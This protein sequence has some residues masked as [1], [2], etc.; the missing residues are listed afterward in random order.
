MGLIT[1]EDIIEEIV[2]EIVDEIDAPS[3]DF[4]NSDGLIIT[5]GEKIYEI[6]ISTLI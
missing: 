4:K 6:C 3:E 1:L 5:N 2:G